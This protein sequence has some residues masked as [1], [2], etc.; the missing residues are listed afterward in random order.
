MAHTGFIQRYHQWTSIC[1]VMLRLNTNVIDLSEVWGNLQQGCK[2]KGWG[3][4]QLEQVPVQSSSSYRQ[5]LC[6][7]NSMQLQNICWNFNVCK[8]YR[9]VS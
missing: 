7:D 8:N 4:K 6:E 9:K 3:C 1:P 2:C 5:Y